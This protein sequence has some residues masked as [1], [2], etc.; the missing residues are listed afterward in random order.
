MQSPSNQQTDSSLDTTMKGH[1]IVV[2]YNS[3]PWLRKCLSAI[4]EHSDFPVSIIDNF[5]SDQSIE[6]ARSIV[7]LGSEV[8][9]VLNQ[10]NLGFATGVNQALRKLEEP[11]AIIIN[12]DCLINAETLPLIERAFSSHPS[13]GLASCTVFSSDG[14]VQR[15]CKRNFPTPWSGFVRVLRLNRLFPSLG[16][17]DQGAS[18][19]VA[20]SDVESMSIGLE[21]VEAISGAFMVA[22]MS[23]VATVGILDEAYF[24]HCEDLDWCKR[25]EL[26]GFKVGFVKHASVTHEKGASSSTRPFGVILN[27]HQGMNLFF[28]KFYATNYH[29]L[30]RVVVKL[31]ICCSFILR[32]SVTLMRQVFHR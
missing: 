16:D 30:T 28:D 6:S 4:L 15:T 3:G 26:A 13:M 17:F 20:M 19:S 14:T 8:S 18:T 5:S 21:F 27:L 25:F 29:F 32:A 9:W 23:S 11:F 24:M 2:N 12:P 22:R 7:K 1:F 10:E 31:G